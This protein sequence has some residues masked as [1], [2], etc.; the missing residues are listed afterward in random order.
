[1]KIYFLD[2]GG[3]TQ[4]TEIPTVIGASIGKDGKSAFEIAVEQGFEGTVTEWLASLVG[5]KGE[6]GDTGATGPKGDTGKQGIQGIKG[7][8]GDVGPQGIQGVKGDTGATGADGQSV[9]IVSFT[10]ED[11]FNNYTPTQYEIVILTN[12]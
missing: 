12:A 2:S 8:T 7:D 5:P 11:T 10:D 3:A 9:T 1:M 6:K 4:I